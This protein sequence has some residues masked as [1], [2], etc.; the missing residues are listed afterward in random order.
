MCNLVFK[1]CIFANYTSDL[2]HLTYMSFIQQKLKIKRFRSDEH[3]AV[4]SIL[5]T[6]SRVQ[7]FHDN[8]FRKYRLTTQQFN[9]LRILRGQYPEPVKVKYIKDLMIDSMSDSSRLIDRLYKQKLVN[10]KPSL[11]D[12]RSMQVT[13]TKLGLDILDAIDKEMK[14]LDEAVAG[15]SQEELSALCRILD[16]I[17][18]KLVPE[19]E[20]EEVEVETNT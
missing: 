14:K 17:C 6:A 11:T 5:Y 8:F 3:Q 7:A 18:S 2:T 1:I 10:R 15:A 12:R 16:G 13:I 20:N 9:V 19:E 4:V